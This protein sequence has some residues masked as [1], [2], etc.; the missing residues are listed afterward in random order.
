METITAQEIKR[1]GISAVD[2]SLKNGPVHII[3]N[4]KPQYVV[5]DEESYLA[6]I[7]ESETAYEARLQIALAEVKKGDL[8]SFKN[9]DE[10]IT[11][12]DSEKE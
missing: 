9:V 6:L 3:K 10:L 2:D 5:M 1:R 11:A 4:N 8:R 12:I 7:S